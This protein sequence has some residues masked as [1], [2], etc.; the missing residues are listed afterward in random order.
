MALVTYAALAQFVESLVSEETYDL[1]EG[2]WKF[3]DGSYSSTCTSGAIRVANEFDGRV[4]GYQADENPAAEIG[5]AY[6]EGHDFAFIA[7]RWIVDYW[8]YHVAAVSPVSVWDLEVAE[9]GK[10]VERLYGNRDTWEG[11]S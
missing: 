5:R 7:N 11:L 4:V 2:A 9:D 8:A 6:G 10:A 3:A 1:E